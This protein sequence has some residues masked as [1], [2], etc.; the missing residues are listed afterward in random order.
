MIFGPCTISPHI[1]LIF[2]DLSQF[3]KAGDLSDAII[4]KSVIG[5]MSNLL[6]RLPL[7]HI[8]EIITK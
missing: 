5:R 2:V 3:E 4:L 6:A 7:D 8:N 1:F